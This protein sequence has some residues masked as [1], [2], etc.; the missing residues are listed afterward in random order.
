LYFFADVLS[1]FI[2]L[3]DIGYYFLLT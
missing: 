2:F 3:K 1:L